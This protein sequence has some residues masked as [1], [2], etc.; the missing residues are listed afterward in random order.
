MKTKET[1]EAKLE[2]LGAV[3]HGEFGRGL[4]YALQWV[5]E[6]GDSHWPKGYGNAEGS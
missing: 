5:L 6:D 3:T 4:R 1:V 2:S